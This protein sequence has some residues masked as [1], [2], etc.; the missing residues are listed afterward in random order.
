ML[1]LD[2]TH[3]PP[4]MIDRLSAPQTQNALR[5][6]IAQLKDLSG[7]AESKGWLQPSPPAGQLAVINAKAAEVRDRADV[8]VLVGVGGSNQGAQAVIGALAPDSKPEVIYAG[9]TLSAHALQQVLEKIKG[10]SVYINVIAK[11]FATL[12][13]GSHF[14]VLR[15]FMASQYDASELA[16]RII[17]T[18]SRGSRLQEIADENGYLFLDFPADIGGRFSAHSAVGLF[19]MAVA[20]IDISQLLQGAEDMA[21][22]LAAAGPR[23]TAAQY[24]A[25]RTLLYNHGFKIEML[26]AFEPQLRL[27]GRWWRQLFGE[28]EGKQRKGIFP[29][30]VIYSEDLHSMGQYLQDGERHLFETFL[31]VTDP[32]ASIVVTPDP[33]FTDNF[34]YLNGLD[35]AEINRKAE[36]ATIA[37]HTAG[38]VPGLILTLPALDA[39]GF[40]Q[41]FYFFEYACALSGLLQGINPFDQEGVEDY[42]RRMFALLKGEQV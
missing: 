11:N 38:G 23:S 27:F 21:K 39:Y 18:G 16:R 10:R 35:F 3:L 36:Q 20:G 1:E 42:K 4:G 40:G 22:Q 25:A 24:A 13:P 26:A 30:T 6:V 15:Q 12:E 8:F 29:S 34:D 31:Q 41:L 28:S 33:G 32:L 5:A 19:P 9:N 7:Q 14:R 17:I 2:L 37:A